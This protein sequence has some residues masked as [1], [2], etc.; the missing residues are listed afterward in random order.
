M[1][2]SI[3]VKR[4][5]AVELVE[6]LLRRLDEEHH[7]WPLSL[8]AEVHVFGSFARGAPEPHDVDIASEHDTT[9][10]RWGSHF[11]TCLA[12]GRNP[13]AP[14]RRML[15]GR[16]RGCQLQFNFRQQNDADL[17]LL[18]RRGDPLAVA[19]QRLHAIPVDPAAQR[20]TREA[21]L[22]QFE[23]LDQ[24]IPLYRRE[25]Q[26]AAVAANALTIERLSLSDG[27]ISSTTARTHVQQRWRAHSPLRR[28]AHAVIAYWETRGIDP[29]QAH[30]HGQDVRDTVTPYFA[31]FNLRYIRS[32]P[33]CLTTFGGREWLEVVHPTTTRPLDCLR[34][35]PGA[36]LEFFETTHCS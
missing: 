6:E 2:N 35:L 34:I 1:R 27:E 7:T 32:L 12:Y 8:I 5:R 33:R 30:L 28:A 9:D 29:G 4:A 19:L 21:M 16:S 36:N 23:G 10:P 13:Y 25:L 26:C 18:W 24:W 31:G 11:A 17:T 20:A 3:C 14:M 15:V 22:P